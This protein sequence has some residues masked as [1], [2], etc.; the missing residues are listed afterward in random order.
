MNQQSIRYYLIT[1]NETSMAYIGGPPKPSAKPG[2]MWLTRPNGE[3]LL[4]IERKCVQ[5]V[6]REH[7][8]ALIQREAIARQAANN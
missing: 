1:T 3:P 5:P 8:A 2:Y 4:E 6:T 7:L